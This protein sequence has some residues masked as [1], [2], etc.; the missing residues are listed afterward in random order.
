MAS[1]YDLYRVYVSA[2]NKERFYSLLA[3]VRPNV[4]KI[5][6]ITPG[7]QLDQVNLVLTEEE[8]SF[9]KLSV[10][11]LNVVWLQEWTTNDRLS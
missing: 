4:S 9:L 7:T 2:A 3:S 5:W 6:H 1:E 11:L 10:S 8:V